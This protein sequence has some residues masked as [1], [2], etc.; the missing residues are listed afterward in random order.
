MILQDEIVHVAN[1][2]GQMYW[3]EVEESIQ[4]DVGLQEYVDK[5]ISKK[6]EELF[7]VFNKAQAIANP[8]YGVG[9]LEQV[10]VEN[11]CNKFVDVCA[12]P[13]LEQ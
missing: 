11:L 2:T 5:A 13:C 3:E 4:S 8:A 12:T 1:E 10:S 6:K 7:T 9:F